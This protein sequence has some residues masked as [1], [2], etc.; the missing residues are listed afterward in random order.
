MQFSP[1]SSYFLLL[2]SQYHQ[3][4]IS[5]IFSPHVRNIKQKPDFFNT[6][7]MDSDYK[8]LSI[9]QLLSTPRLSQ[10]VILW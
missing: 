7:V 3:V 4:S 8:R 5:K 9:S 6:D 2:G 10:V 1:E